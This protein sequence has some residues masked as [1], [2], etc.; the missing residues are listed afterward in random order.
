VLY[1]VSGLAA[2]KH[3]IKLVK[4]SGQYLLVDAFKVK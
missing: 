2:G 3:Q 1:S 4:L